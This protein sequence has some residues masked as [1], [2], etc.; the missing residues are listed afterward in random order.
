MHDRPG[1]LYN[2]TR[3]ISRFGVDIRAAIVATL[4]AEVFDTLYITD[5]LGG[6]LD[7]ERAKRLA[8]QIEQQMLTM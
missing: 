5:A 1:L 7:E 4:G 3:T 8:S 2:V 6:A